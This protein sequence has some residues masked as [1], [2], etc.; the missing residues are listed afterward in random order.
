VKI[1]DLE[2]IVQDPITHCQWLETLSYLENCGA[3]KIKRYENPRNI[4]LEILKHGAEEARHAYFFKNQ[5]GK[6]QN[7]QEI[8][9]S[10]MGGYFV[11]NYLKLLDLQISRMLKKCGSRGR[12][13]KDKSYLLVTYTIEVRAK[14]LYEKYERVLKKL[15]ASMSIRSVII[16]E[17]N[18]LL[19]MRENI[20]CD[21]DLWPLKAEAKILELRLYSKLCRE[22]V[23]DIS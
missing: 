13:L 16:E 21:K 9:Y 20:F 4:T 11:R 18:H 12:K 14:E 6:I 1:E 5:I 19:E 7:D 3:R 22:I 23:K 8:N 15:G 17:D 10:L 2:K